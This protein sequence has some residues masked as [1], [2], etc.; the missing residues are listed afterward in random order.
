LVLLR[1]ASS[2]WR[3]AD[4]SNSQTSSA[5]LNS[6]YSFDAQPCL[7]RPFFGRF[8]AVLGTVSWTRGTNTD[9]R[10]TD[11]PLSANLISDRRRA[12]RTTPLS[13]THECLLPQPHRGR[14][15]LHTAPCPTAH[16]TGLGAGAFPPHAHAPH[17]CP[18][19]H[20]PHAHTHP[21]GGPGG[22]R[23]WR[24][25]HSP[26]SRCFTAARPYLPLHKQ[27]DFGRWRTEEGREGEGER[28]GHLWP[29]GRH[30]VDGQAGKQPPGRGAKRRNQRRDGQYYPVSMPFA[31][32][33]INIHRRALLGA[34]HLTLP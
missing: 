33:L 16:P 7:Q 3:P 29:P 32:S 30:C 4:D 6:V 31:T 15:H 23:T 13:T 5:L 21:T 9:S 22:R 18:T 8:C 19:A 11:E 1:T 12:P 24:Q 27:A 2:G 14:K 28:R 26:V 20:P 25:F 34:F 17:T 10:R